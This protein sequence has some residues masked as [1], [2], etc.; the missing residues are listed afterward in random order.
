MPKILINRSCIVS[1]HDA[2][3][4]VSTDTSSG[5]RC[6]D[7]DRALTAVQRIEWCEW[8]LAAAAPAQKSLQNICVEAVDTFYVYRRSESDHV[9]RPRCIPAKS[10]E[11]AVSALWLLWPSTRM[12]RMRGRLEGRR[13]RKSFCL[14]LM[15]WFRK[16]REGTQ[17]HIITI[18][19]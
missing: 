11:Q 12:N 7:A 2:A 8:L 19:E 4:V 9:G 5:R 13:V 10:H 15:T 18:T 6:Q 16:H 14:C 1:I 3:T 17:K